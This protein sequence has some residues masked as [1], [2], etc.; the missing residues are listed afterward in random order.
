MATAPQLLR[1]ARRD[2][3]LTQ[4]DVA[5]RLGTSQPAIAK[6]ERAG[7]NPTLGTLERALGATGHRLALVRS[8]VD[9][10]LVRRQLELPPAERIRQLEHQAA[11]A[12]MLVLAG[13]RA[14]GDLP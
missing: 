8:T 2:A 9:E 10:S 3:G 6:L 5:A 14:R 12:R 1:A 11:Q 7:A 13:A 4:A